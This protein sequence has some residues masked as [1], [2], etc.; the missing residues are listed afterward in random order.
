[1]TTDKKRQFDA[2]CD[3][4]YH[5]AL[6]FATWIA[7]DAE[8]AHDILQDAL[9]KAYRAFEKSDDLP[10]GWAWLYQI[11][12]R[13]HIDRIRAKN[14]RIATVSLQD[15]L[16]NHPEFD[17]PDSDQSPEQV[18][19]GNTPDPGLEHLIGRLTPEEQKAVRLSLRDDIDDSERARE[20]DCSVRAFKKRMLKIRRNLLQSV[21]VTGVLPNS[22]KEQAI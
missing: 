7:R 6:R 1:M 21:K 13:T 9:V 2:F 12:R 5:R 17:V 19:L 15:H 4:S 14:R 11:I 8:E 10:H 20:L 3:N 16:L 18:V 22:L